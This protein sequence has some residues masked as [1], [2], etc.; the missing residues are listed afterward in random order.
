MSATLTP[1]ETT[2]RRP[3]PGDARGAGR[4]AGRS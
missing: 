3:A 4:P 2:R 1:T